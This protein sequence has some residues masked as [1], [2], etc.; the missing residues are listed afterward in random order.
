MIIAK[1]D[2]VVFRGEYSSYYISIFNDGAYCPSGSCACKRR[3][4]ENN[5]AFPLYC[6]VYEIEDLICRDYKALLVS[7]EDFDEYVSQCASKDDARA[8]I[9]QEEVEKKKKRISI[10]LFKE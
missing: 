8:K 10:N 2:R 4:I 9:K 6:R 7:E 5:H 1:I 3:Q